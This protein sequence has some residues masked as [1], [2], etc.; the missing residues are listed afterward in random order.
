[1]PRATQAKRHTYTV[2]QF[3]ILGGGR[4]VRI[5]RQRA[6]PGEDVSFAPYRTQPWYSGRDAHGLSHSFPEGSVQQ[7]TTGWVIDNFAPRQTIPRTLAAVVNKRRTHRPAP[8]ANPAKVFSV[9][10]LSWNPSGAPTVSTEREA[11]KEA[12]KVSQFLLTAVPAEITTKA[13][14]NL[15]DY[16]AGERPELVTPDVRSRVHRAFSE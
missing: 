12:A 4:V 11:T 10:E 9:L 2:G 1:M 16:V 3:V 5:T 8:L 13:I 6:T 14:K 7:V 15:L